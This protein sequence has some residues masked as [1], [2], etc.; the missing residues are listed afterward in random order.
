[1]ATD[2]VR[3]QSDGERKE[4]VGGGMRVPFRVPFL[5][6]PCPTHS[7]HQGQIKVPKMLLLYHSP[8]CKPPATPTAWSNASL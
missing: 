2:R 7:A 8:V 1:M 4:K 6:L 5:S 3:D